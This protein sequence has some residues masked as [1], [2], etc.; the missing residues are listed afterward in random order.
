MENIE[1][2]ANRL[3]FFVSPQRHG[4]HG[5]FTSRPTQT[6]AD[7]YRSLKRHMGL[8]M[9]LD[10]QACPVASKPHMLTSLRLSSPRCAWTLSEQK[11]QSHARSL[12]VARA[13]RAH[14]GFICYV[15]FFCVLYDSAKDMGLFTSVFF[16]LRVKEAIEEG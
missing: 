3:C 10:N 13:S 6:K 11:M 14:R 2:R 12:R 4:G 9:P 16:C 8:A 5:G 15:L 1:S 7:N